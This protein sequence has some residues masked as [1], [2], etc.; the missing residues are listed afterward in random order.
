[1]LLLDLVLLLAVVY[2]GMQFRAA[3]KAK[4]AREAATLNRLAK[5][6]PAPP[7][8]PPGQEPPVTPAHYLSIAERMLFD[9]SRNPNVPIEPPPPP[10][11]PPPMP[12]LP[13]YHGV[14]TLGRGGLTAFFS[15]TADSPHQAIHLGENIGQFKLLGVNTEEIT[16]EWNGNPVVKKISEVT[17]HDAPPAT[18]AAGARTEAPTAPIAPPPVK[19]GP[20]E[21]TAF[22]NKTCA[23]NDGNAEG[24]VIDGY[25]KVHHTNPFGTNCTWDPVSK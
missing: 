15:T 6:I 21:T 20:G 9:R 17:S 3:T 23:I 24:T 13:V 19:S 7:F 10:P 4:K 14:M 25:K 1:M 18:Q 11:P 12:P 16:F 8:I 2:V 5:P 22:G